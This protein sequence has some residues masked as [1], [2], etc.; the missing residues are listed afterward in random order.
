MEVQEG[1]S[2]PVTIGW[3]LFV[4]KADG[5]EVVV[6]TKQRSFG[7]GSPYGLRELSRESVAVL[8]PA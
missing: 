2:C 3:E 6:C 1:S 4:M 7:A 5:F 8:N